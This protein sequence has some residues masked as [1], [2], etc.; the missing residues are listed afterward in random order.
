M[1]RITNAELLNAGFR[2]ALS[3]CADRHDAED[4][5]HDAWLRLARRYDRQPEKPLLFRTIRNLFIDK[6]R[7]KRVMHNYLAREGAGLQQEQVVEV[8]LASH[9][10][11]NDEL[12]HYLSRLRDKE[13]EALFLSVVEGYTADEIAAMTDTVRGT[14]LSLIFRARKKLRGWIEADSAEPRDNV[15]DLAE[16]AAG[17]RAGAQPGR[18]T[19]NGRS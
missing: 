13:R 14:V 9:I 6:C 18:Q 5:V 4:L 2:Y 17:R 12:A 16:R 1:N 3:L 10:I 8:D 15:V 19:S 11:D 7:R